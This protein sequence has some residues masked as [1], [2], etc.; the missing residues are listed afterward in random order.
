MKHGKDNKILG[1]TFL[2]KVDW[3]DTKLFYIYSTS[4]L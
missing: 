1:L 4:Y 3:F 2:I